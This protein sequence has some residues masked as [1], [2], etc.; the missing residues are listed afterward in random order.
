M[1][2]IDWIILGILAL[3]MLISI[4]RGFVREALSL[5]TWVAA[6]VVARLFSA[7]LAPY[8][9]N[10][11]AAS[12]TRLVAAFVL[13]FVMTLIVGAMI[14]HLVCE[15][16]R[17]TGLSGTDRLLGMFFGLARGVIVLV[18]AVALVKLTPLSK[19][20][21]WEESTLIPEL[22]RLEQLSRETFSNHP[23]GNPV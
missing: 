17:L 4:K 8:L 15:L 2:E 6:F 11:I 7:E 18:V 21:W 19:D 14:N 16:I 12:S 5:V 1:N 23:G 3:S 9:A 22:L 13:L 20:K 10:Y